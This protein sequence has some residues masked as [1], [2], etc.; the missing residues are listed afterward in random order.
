MPDFDFFPRHF[1]SFFELTTGVTIALALRYALTAGIA[2]ALGYWIFKTR[3]LHRKIVAHF[4]A[5]S[6]VRREIAYSASSVVLFAIIGALTVVASKAGWTQMYWRVGEYGWPW[7]WAS[8]GLAIVLH[9]TYFYWTHRLM[10]HPRLFRVF[11][12]VHHLSH[13][14]TPWAAYSFAPAEAVVEA[15]ILPLA[16]IVM[17]M[18]PLAFAIF[19]GWQITYNVIGH[20]GYEIHPRWLMDTWLGKVLNT[21]TNHTMHH[22]FVRGNYGLYFNVW[23][24]LMGTNHENYEARFREVTSQKKTARGAALDATAPIGDHEPISPHASA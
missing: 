8:I 17:P 9:D 24:R 21:P 23:D 6:E 12:R 15:G 3:W 1:P 2:W 20:A 13:N 19:M 10:H 14:P 22:E 16:V 5:S 4:P 11:H 18:H 7:F